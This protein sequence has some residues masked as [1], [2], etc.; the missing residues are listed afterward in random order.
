ML[1]KGY[2]INKIFYSWMHSLHVE[3]FPVLIFISLI[4]LEDY[5][6]SKK[7]CWRMEIQL[8]ALQVAWK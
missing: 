8:T 1:A 4:H 3:Y 5:S 6:Q 7:F 2:D